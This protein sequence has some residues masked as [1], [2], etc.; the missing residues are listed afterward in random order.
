MAWIS[1]TVFAPETDEDENAIAEEDVVEDVVEPRKKK[2][3]KF[4]AAASA[5]ELLKLFYIWFWPTF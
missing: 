4:L 2:E 5:Y 1:R 3:K